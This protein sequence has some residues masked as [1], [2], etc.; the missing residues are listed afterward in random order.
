[1]FAF[2]RTL[3]NSRIRGG[4]EGGKVVTIRNLTQNYWDPNNVNP[5]L[6]SIQ[7]LQP[8]VGLLNNVDIAVGKLLQQRSPS[9]ARNIEG[10]ITRFK[11]VRNIVEYRS[12][13]SFKRNEAIPQ[14]E[15]YISLRTISL[16]A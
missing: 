5:I 10:D 8:I 1:M 15:A 16:S 2:S 6:R 12:S 7:Y 4:G 14:W 3:E 9:S 13:T 11:T